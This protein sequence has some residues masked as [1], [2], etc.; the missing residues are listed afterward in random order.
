MMAKF[1]V[2]KAA[3]L[4]F[5]A[6]RAD[7]PTLK[8]PRSCDTVIHVTISASHIITYNYRCDIL[9]TYVVS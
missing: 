5:A 6:V 2:Y 9:L 3:W 8:I 1:F 4:K 7:R